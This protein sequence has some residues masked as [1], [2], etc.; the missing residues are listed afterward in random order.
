[1][2]ALTAIFL[3]VVT[4]GP[5]WAQSGTSCTNSISSGTLAFG[6]VVPTSPAGV[7]I[8]L[9]DFIVRCSN[10]DTSSRNVRLRLAISAGNSGNA[11]QRQ[12]IR[13][14]APVPLLYNL[15]E[16]AAYTTVWTATTGGRPDE[17]LSVPGSST[18]E[19]RRQIFGR[20]PGGQT[21][22]TAG[23]YSDTLIASV[24]Y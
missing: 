24:R 3:A 21:T 17:V 2:R 8:L 11:A 12:M 10:P 4:A 5:T 6:N 13:A 18:A 1:M 14:G 19:L 9:G 20:I 15:Y 23:L 7:S 22:V 16:D